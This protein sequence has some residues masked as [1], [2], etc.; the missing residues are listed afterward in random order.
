LGGTGRADFAA[1]T[2]FQI[3]KT[4]ALRLGESLTRDWLLPCRDYN[5]P[6][7][8]VAMRMVPVLEDP[9]ADRKVQNAA[10]LIQAGVEIEVAELRKAAGFRDPRPG[11]PTVG[12]RSAQ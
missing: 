4:D 1:D 12:G 8:K 7:S 10:V 6:G 2:K 9:R 11:K 3:V 5:F